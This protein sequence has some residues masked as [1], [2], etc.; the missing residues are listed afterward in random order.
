MNNKCNKSFKFELK[1]IAKPIQLLIVFDVT[2]LYISSQGIGYIYT[3]LS[4]NQGTNSG[5]KL[6][7]VL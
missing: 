1:I 6:T 2:I 7:L 5:L 3:E 4:Y